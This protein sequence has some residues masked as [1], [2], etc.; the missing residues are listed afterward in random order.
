M[1]QL[2]L[3]VNDQS[4]IVSVVGFGPYLGDHIVFVGEVGWVT[5]WIGDEFEGA[6]YHT[7]SFVS[8]S[9]WGSALTFLFFVCVA[10]A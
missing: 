7:V 5:E 10:A 3:I 4:F 6:C 1:L 2:H 8:Y 9:V